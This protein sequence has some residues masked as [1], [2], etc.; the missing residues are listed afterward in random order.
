MRLLTF[1]ALLV[2]AGCASQNGAGTATPAA[3]NAPAQA[4]EAPVAQVAS[5]PA[6]GATADAQPEAVFQP[7]PG[8]KRRPD[9]GPNIY[10][11]KIKVL[12]SRFPKDDCRT[13]T[14]LRDIANQRAA[15][16]GEMDSRGRVCS[17]GGACQNQ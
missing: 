3:A 1:A 4:G 6:A 11:T 8:Y 13:E 5:T 17:G 16:R 10:C 7:P 15:G 12:G 2:L 14:E 9:M